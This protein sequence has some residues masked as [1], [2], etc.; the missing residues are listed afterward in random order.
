MRTM[1]S[2]NWHSKISPEA[3]VAEDR[4]GCFAECKTDAE[5]HCASVESNLVLVLVG[6]RQEPTA[7][8][9]NQHDE[10]RKYSCDEEI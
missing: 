1:E 2:F 9:K 7:H 3:A 4:E 8:E 5:K 6:S 10:H